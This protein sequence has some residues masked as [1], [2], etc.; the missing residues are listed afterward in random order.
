MRSESLTKEERQLLHEKLD[1]KSD[2]QNA[3]HRLAELH[4]QIAARRGGQPL[5]LDTEDLVEQLHQMREER[6]QQLMDACFPTT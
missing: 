4:D 6:T 1:R 2:W 3:R 5:D